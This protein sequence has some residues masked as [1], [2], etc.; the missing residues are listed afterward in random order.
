MQELEELK[1]IIKKEG[2]SHEKLARKLGV[3]LG[4]VVRWLQNKNKP[5]DLALAQI[6]KFIS[7]YKK[8]EK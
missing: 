5:S 8:E 4:T 3:S 1:K 2:L 6:R 7:E